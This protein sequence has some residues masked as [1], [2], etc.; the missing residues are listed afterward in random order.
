VILYTIGDSWTYGWGLENPKT[1]CYPYLLS[2]KLDC[3]L[4]NE[5]LPAASND[6]MFRKSIEWILKNDISQ[7]KLFIV[8]W[9]FPWRREENFSFYHGGDPESERRSY[10][11]NLGGEPISKWISENL[12]DVRLSYLKTYTYIYTL[13]EILKSKNINYLFYHPLDPLFV[14]DEWYEENIKS[15]VHDIYLHIDLNKSVGPDFD[16]KEVIPNGKP[17]DHPNKEQTEWLSNQLFNFI[18]ENNGI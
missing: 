14:Q 9:S 1:E 8:G 7:L 17:N 16:G 10:G 11:G 2:K 4:V 18:E 13:Q 6:W 3:D 12:Y 15:L 5:G